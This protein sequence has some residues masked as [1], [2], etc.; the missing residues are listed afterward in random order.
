MHCVASLRPKL[1]SDYLI[2]VF[3]TASN[4][5][6]MIRHCS[7]PFNTSECQKCLVVF[8]SAS[9]VQGDGHVPSKLPFGCLELCV[10]LYL[11]AVCV[12]LY[13]HVCVFVFAFV[14]VCVFVFVFVFVVAVVL[15]F[16]IL[17]V[18]FLTTQLASFFSAFG[19]FLEI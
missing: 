15:V 19:K 10:C 1:E 9:T 11:Y 6:D 13:L 8:M 4:K 16:L 12:C 5:E 18:F 7:P 2:T 3:Q 17:F 14:C